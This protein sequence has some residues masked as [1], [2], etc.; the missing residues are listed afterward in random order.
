MRIETERLVL[1]RWVPGDAAALAEIHA[2]PEVAAYLDPLTRDDTAAMI[3]RYE[4]HW[5]A[6]GF[7]RF[8][9]AD[10]FS[11]RLVGRLGVMR[12]P[13]WRATREKDEIGWTIARDRWG[14]G[15]ATEAAIATLADAFDRVRLPRI[16][17]WTALE[18]VSSQRVMARCGMRYRGLTLWKGREHVWYDLR[19]RETRD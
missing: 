2:H 19:N 15:L 5:D 3:D 1:R 13:S 10:R 8:A 11:G 16:V 6:H 9:V 7:A 4:R 14:E 12:E 17:S 18:N